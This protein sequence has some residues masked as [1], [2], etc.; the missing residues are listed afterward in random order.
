ML[1]NVSRSSCL[2]SGNESINIVGFIIHR[3]WN[4]NAYEF[5]RNQYSAMFSSNNNSFIYLSLRW[6]TSFYL[7]MFL[8]VWNG[9]C[10]S[11]C[12]LSDMSQYIVYICQKSWY[13]VKLPLTWDVMTLMW[14]HWNKTITCSIVCKGYQPALL[15]VLVPGRTKL[16]QSPVSLVTYKPCVWIYDWDE[17]GSSINIS[18]CCYKVIHS[19]KWVKLLGTGHIMQLPKLYF[20]LSFLVWDEVIPFG[21]KCIDPSLSAVFCCIKWHSAEKT[22]IGCRRLLVSHSCLLHSANWAI[23]NFRL[24]HII[25]FAVL[26]PRKE[27]KWVT[28][29]I[30]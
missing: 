7:I 6:S 1:S 2:K 26:V 29:V 27:L 11:V 3:C 16:A 12:A 14:C 30:Q 28:G 21:E 20:W 18:I 8:R 5:G 17:T 19:C 9:N 25:I 13:T 15:H 23:L 4:W 10:M 24:T 22:L